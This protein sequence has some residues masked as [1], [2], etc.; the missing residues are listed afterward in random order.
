MQAGHLL[1]RAR[2]GSPRSQ[3][4]DR[5]TT[6]APRAMPRTPHSSLNW[7][8]PS[9]RRVPPDQSTTRSAAAASAASGSRRRQL[10]GDA[11]EAGAERERLDPPAPD[12]R[13]V[14][15][16][17]QGPGVGL[18]RAAHVAQQHEPAGPLGR[19]RRTPRAIGSP[20]A[21]SACAHRAPQ[22]GPAALAPGSAAGAATRRSAPARRRSA[23]SRRA[24]ANSAGAV[25]GEVRVA[26]HLGAAVAHRERRAVG[27][28]SPSSSAGVVVAVGVV[29]GERDRARLG[30]R[31]RARSTRGPARRRAKPRS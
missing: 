4:S 13:G 17:H 9:P 3:P 8:R 18:H 19:A 5:I 26:Q 22:V 11:G 20:P 12:D 21:R 6:T 15:E 29:D 25:G 1:G 7:R 30:R 24:S 27:V 10:A 16:A 28:G 23:I 14:Q 2:S 31:R